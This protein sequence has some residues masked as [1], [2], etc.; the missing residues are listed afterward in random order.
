V[1]CVVGSPFLS[2]NS[3]GTGTGCVIFA[4]LMLLLGCVAEMV[5]GTTFGSGC[6]CSAHLS[7]LLLCRVGLCYFL[8]L[9]VLFLLSGWV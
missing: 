7:M 9:L 6:R 2:P 3:I 8:D 1:I 5:T 4:Y